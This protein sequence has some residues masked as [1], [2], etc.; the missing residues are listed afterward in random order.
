MENFISW[1]RRISQ[2][3]MG[4]MFELFSELKKV[5]PGFSSFSLRD[6][7]EDTK[8]LKALFEG[9]T[10]KGSISFDFGELSDGQRVI[11]ALYALIYCMKGEGLTLFLDEPDNFV[12]LREIQP[13]LATLEEE[14]GEGI[15][16]AVL[17]SH[18]PRIINFLGNS[19]GRWF[20]REG[21]G[22]TRLSE[23]APPAVDG[24]SL[25]ETIAR[26]WEE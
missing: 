6:S 26:G 11:I 15:E 16:Q 1:Y 7:G 22:H 25:S 19:N 8:S 21:A 14:V 3:N 23:E 2:Q 9:A 10:P 20:S 24:L 4:A 13:W 18:H 17:I 12:A 5:L